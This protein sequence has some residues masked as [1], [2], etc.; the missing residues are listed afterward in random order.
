MKASRDE[1]RTIE[2]VSCNEQQDELRS[3][4]E[5]NRGHRL[6]D[7]SSTFDKGELHRGLH[8][9]HVQM[10][11]IAGCIGT[12]LFLGS[13]N[14][15]RTAGPLGALIGYALVCS[16]VY[17]TLC[18]VAEMAS[19]A[20]ISGSFPYYATRWVDPALGFASGWIYYSTYALAAPAEISASVIL[21]TYWDSNTN[22]IA[23][24]TAIVW[25]VVCM[26]SLFGVRYFGESEVV[27][28]SIKI[29][30]I[31]GL[32]LCGLV[33]DLG[34]GPRGDRIGFRFW[35]NPG[36]LNRAGL[37]DNINTDRF[38]AIMSTIVQAAFSLNGMELVAISSSETESPR[39][40]IKKAVTRVFYRLMAFYILGILM[41]G[42]LVAHNDPALL[43][44]SQT[45]AASPFVI[46]I[47]RAGIEVLPSVI[48]AAIFTSAL[49]TSNTAVYLSSRIL[50]GLSLHRQ[51]PRI[52]TRCTKNGLPI[53][54][55][56]T[57]LALSLLSFLNVRDGSQQ[58][59]TWL[60]GL[61]ALGSLFGWITMNVTYLFFH[62]GMRVQNYDLKQNVYNHPLQPYLAVY[63]LLW[64]LI[65]VLING[66]AVFFRWNASDF[67]I[68]YINIPIFALLY[69]GYKI[70]KRTKIIRPEE[71]DF[72]TG[73]PTLEETEIPQRPTRNV[74]HT[75][76]R[77]LV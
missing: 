59:F 72:V 15:L 24:Y 49:S 4:E 58:V 74:F 9:R 19:F 33:I 45:A 46:A 7:D 29:S 41:I 47:K 27:F 16:V 8:Q 32:L 30:L 44:P 68:S 40:N 64:S 31:I 13:G 57:T 6:E 12:G 52:L 53:A 66:Y 65:F 51:A 11:A 70:I 73:I 38:L 48:N 56:G 42:M 62:R 54:A 77:W 21:L 28:A 60:S 22:H 55:V 25:I 43:N 1:E 14:S 35:K 26:F 34:G 75:F 69:F 18:S 10:I 50:Y 63:G 36:A 67:V 20:P 5:A 17:C 71:M 61:V 2:I 37:V 39:R 76:I 23:L 3:I